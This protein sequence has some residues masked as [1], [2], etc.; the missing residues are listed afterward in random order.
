MASLDVLMV[1]RQGIWEGRKTSVEVCPHRS[2][3]KRSVPS[4]ESNDMLKVLT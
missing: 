3:G 4:M 1:L 2:Q